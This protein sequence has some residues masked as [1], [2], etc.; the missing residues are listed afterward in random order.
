MQKSKSDAQRRAQNKYYRDKLHIVALK[1]PL[2]EYEE[3]ARAAREAGE[4][5]A[6]Y[7]RRAVAARMSGGMVDTGAAV[8]DG[9]GEMEEPTREPVEWIP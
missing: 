9:P 5:V 2:A 7:A 1:Y 6:T 4:P 3:V 8:A